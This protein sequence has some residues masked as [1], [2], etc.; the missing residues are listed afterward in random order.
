MAGKISQAVVIAAA[1]YRS[2]EEFQERTGIT[3][4]VLINDENHTNTH[5]SLGAMLIHTSTLCL[6]C[7]VA[8]TAVRVA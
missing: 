2:E 7:H 8:A 3:Q 6:V 4:S 1:A 5:V